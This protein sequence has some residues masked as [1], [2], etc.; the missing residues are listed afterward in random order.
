MGENQIGI[1]KKK[2]SFPSVSCQKTGL[3]LFALFVVVV[4]VNIEP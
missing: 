2:Q 4:V 3:V 1:G